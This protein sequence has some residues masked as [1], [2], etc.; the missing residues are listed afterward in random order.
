MIKAN[1]PGW[2]R[3]SYL[4]LTYFASLAGLYSAEGSSTDQS[5]T[6]EVVVEL[7]AFEVLGSRIRLTDVVGPSPV[8]IYGKSEIA[9]TG[10]MT[11]AE[12]LNRLPQNYNGISAGRGSTPN[13][14]NPEFGARTETS[15]VP[16]NLASGSFAP[17][18]NATGQS[19][20]SLRG[21]GSSATLILIDGRRVA[22]SS[23]GNQG[24]DSKQGYVDLN[25]IPLGMVENVEVITDGASALYGADAVAGVINIVLKKNWSGTELSSSYKS[26]FTG[27]EGSETST[28]LVHGFSS[29]SLR[30]TVSLDYFK[31]ESLKASDRPYSASQN[32]T[33]II[34]GYNSETGDPIYG[35]NYLLNWGYP[36]TV[37][38][39]SGFLN[40]ILDPNGKATRVALTPEGFAS[41]PETTDGFIGVAPSGT[42]PLTDPVRARTGNSSEFLDL[43]PPS[44]RKGI[45]LR[46]TF[47]LPEDMELTANLLHSN[48]SG[49]SSGQPPAFNASSTTG[50][51]KITSIVPAAYN[52]FQQDVIVGMMVYEFGG[53]MQTVS[54]ESLNSSIGLTAP[55]GE[56]WRVDGSLNWQQQDFS[57]ITRDFNANFITAALASPDPDQR[58]NPFLDARVRGAPD[59]SALWESMARYILFDGYS[60]QFS[61]DLTAD[62]ELFDFRGDAVRMAAGLYY[63]DLRVSNQSLVPS[64][65]LT[66]E[67]TLTKTEGV[68]TGIAVFSELMVPVFGK[69]TARPGFRRL[70]A[71]L[72]VR[73]EDRGDAG[74]A[75]VPKVGM[76]WV[77]ME[78]ILLRAGYAEGFR[79]PGPTE[80]M[81]QSKDF[82]RNTLIDPRRGD[83]VTNGI[84]VTRGANLNL[85]P[86]TSRS[87]YT[88]VLYEPAFI[89]GFTLDIN[90]Y[91]TEQDNIIQFLSEQVLVNNEAT[92]SERIIRAD[93][94]SVDV[95]NGWPGQIISIDRSLLNFG[96]SENHSL[97]INIRYKLATKSFGSLQFN[98]SGTHTLKSLRELEPGVAVVDDTGDTFSPP[99]W[100]FNGSIYWTRGSFST[101][102]F[103]N[104]LSKFESNSAGLISFRTNLPIPSQTKVDLRVSY[105]LSKNISKNWGKGTRFSIGIGNLFNEDPPFSDTVYGYNGTFHNPLGR[106]YQFSITV[107]F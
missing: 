105:E 15:S 88:G 36:A 53:V 102:V 94:D 27:S 86:E 33:D 77:P 66:P 34:K 89:E 98:L 57:R 69:D 46:L 80:T 100:R 75:T 7:E 83:M 44:E 32:Y 72:A 73:H 81:V 18:A 97:D 6:G 41:M 38:A 26:A 24:T 22:K 90:Y 16:Y 10:A 21:L 13:D 43:I 76:S 59:Q 103:I 106:N 54:T 56:T 58:I 45:G 62:G 96:R 71:Q 74:N 55:I 60:G 49:T 17:P 65:S 92:F 5:S 14:L 78:S 29:G 87:I 51:G 30:G 20:V 28:S 11:L 104:Y 23:I 40:G 99:K 93:P 63:E 101:S 1:L 84:L 91:I 79:A 52:P 9:Q 39:R 82:T 50:F 68:G 8:S 42:S 95:A 4:L 107:P 31:R 64:L 70:D 3:L 37:Q 85:L 2:I 12:F 47:A 25:S 35:S 19:G 67:D 61:F 48:S